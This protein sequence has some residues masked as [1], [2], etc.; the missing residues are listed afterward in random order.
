M[1]PLF[2]A[3]QCHKKGEEVFGNEREVHLGTIE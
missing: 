2:H 3:P 1:Y